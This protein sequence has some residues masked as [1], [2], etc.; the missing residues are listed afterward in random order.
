MAPAALTAV[1][2]DHTSLAGRLEFIQDGLVLVGHVATTETKQHY[3]LHGRLQKRMHLKEGRGG[4]GRGGVGRG[5]LHT[6][7]GCYTG[8]RYVYCKAARYS[9]YETQLTVAG[10]M[11]G[12]SL[13][14]PTF[15]FISVC[16][17]NLSSSPPR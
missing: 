15:A 5:S 2:D 11:P 3:P 1:D 14:M 17:L 9:T 6:G 16:T 10:V 12:K 8:N 13:R 7:G 4:V